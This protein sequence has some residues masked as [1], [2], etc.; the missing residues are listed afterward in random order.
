MS[1]KVIQLPDKKMCPI[2][3]QFGPS[4]LVVNVHPFPAVGFETTFTRSEPR[5]TLSGKLKVLMGMRKS[6]DAIET[7][8]SHQAAAQIRGATVIEQTIVSDCAKCGRRITTDIHRM[9]NSK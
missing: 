9:G 2:F 6:C 4:K 1:E 3:D 5:S 8:Y 7:F